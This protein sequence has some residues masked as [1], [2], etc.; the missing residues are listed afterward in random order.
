MKTVLKIALGVSLAFVQ[1]IAA[2]SGVTGWAERSVV[3]RGS[4][5][6]LVLR[7]EVRVEEVMVEA[8]PDANFPAVVAPPTGERP[9]GL[10]LGEDGRVEGRR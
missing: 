1:L 2:G 5:S 6:D 9:L 8:A 3:A 7:G 10:P 4:S